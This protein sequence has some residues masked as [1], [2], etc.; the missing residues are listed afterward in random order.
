MRKWQQKG[1]D[2]DRSL[3]SIYTQR[4][5]DYCYMKLEELMNCTGNS[6]GK[7][8]LDGFFAPQW[9]RLSHD[10]G[11]SSFIGTMELRLVQ[12]FQTVAAYVE[13]F[14]ETSLYT[15]GPNLWGVYHVHPIQLIRK[16]FAVTV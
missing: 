1:S 13:I 12:G 7:F 9:T 2:N 16:L 10:S 6:C 5:S 11:V 4:G 3:E 14:H 15:E 8:Q